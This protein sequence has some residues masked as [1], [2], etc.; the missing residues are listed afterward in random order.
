MTL[1]AKRREVLRTRAAPVVAQV[2][3]LATLRGIGGNRAWVFG[4]AFFAW[5]HG[6]TPKQ[7]GAGA[8]LTPTPYH[9]GEVSRA[10]GITKA[11]HGD[12]RTMAVE[13]AWGWGRLQPQSTLTPWSQARL[14]QGSARLRTIGMVAL[15]RQ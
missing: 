2:R 15:A 10:L 11:G 4:M 6:Q 7:G 5:R 14:G 1:E 3:Q 9:S 8:G 12:R 13:L